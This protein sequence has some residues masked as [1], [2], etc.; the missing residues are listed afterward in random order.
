MTSIAEDITN[1]IGGTPLVRPGKLGAELVAKLKSFNPCSIVEGRIGLS[2]IEAEEL[3][4][5]DSR[6]LLLQQFAKPRVFARSSQRA[7][8][9]NLSFVL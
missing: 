1:L 6:Y 3:A 7:D 9:E 8:S 4:A 2:M 5:S